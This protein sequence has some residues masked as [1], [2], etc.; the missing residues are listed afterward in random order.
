MLTPGDHEQPEDDTL[1]TNDTLRSDEVTPSFD[2][3]TNAHAHTTT[4]TTTTTRT[5][6]RTLYWAF[7]LQGV[8]MLFPWNVF[9]TAASYFA[10]R[11]AGTPFEHSFEQAFSFSYTSANLVVFLALLKFGATPSFDLR[12]AI[13]TPN[14][15][16]AFLFFLASMFV[17]TPME[18]EL[19][20]FLTIVS[21]LLCGGFAACLQA[22]IFGLT[23]RL[24]TQYTQAVV[25]GQGAAGATVS[26][27]SLFS[28]LSQDC[29]TELQRP[30]LAEITPQ[31]FGYF[32]AS[33]V[34]V[35]LCLGV[36]VW[37]SRTNI[38]IEKI[39]RGSDG[40]S[41]TF[42]V[43]RSP[44]LPS[45]ETTLRSSDSSV[46][47]ATAWLTLVKSL[48]RHCLGVCLT[49]TAT[50]AVFPGLTADIKSFNNPYDVPCP[51]TGMLYGYGIWQS[52]LFL[53]FNVGDTVGRQLTL[54]GPLIPPR[55]VWIVT[56]VRLLFVPLFMACNLRSSD[57]VVGGGGGNAT[58]G[59]SGSGSGSDS[60]SGWSPSS[61]EEHVVMGSG[62]DFWPCLLMLMMA[63]SN[64][65]C[66]GLEMMNGPKQVNRLEDQS[67]AGTLMGFFMTLGLLL[68]SLVAFPV[69]AIVS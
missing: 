10:L 20:Y 2:G 36:F 12:A 4:T 58:S 51:A 66:A 35:L 3:V 45:A 60:G 63:I 27:L 9:I 18:G 44:A 41:S 33:A 22:G 6:S 55:K 39:N 53:L 15:I 67:R 43:L 42:S 14:V 23:A 32:F 38:V 52:W 69:R 21:V 30:T 40:S 62:S 59:G 54:L 68:G 11:F 17:L 65:Y 56:I 29:G 31:S 28:L 26:L 8:G 13:V 49:F 25:G 57:E 64:G 48:W 47:G 50:L 19:L 46:K 34:V 1:L 37:I 24:P 5:K 61:S 16:T 7:F